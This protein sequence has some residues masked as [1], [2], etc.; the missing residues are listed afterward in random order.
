MNTT[1][2]LKNAIKVFL[3]GVKNGDIIIYPNSDTTPDYINMLETA[4][5]KVEQYEREQNEKIEFTRVNSDMYGNPRYVCHY[6]NLIKDSDKGDRAY[7]LYELALK[8][9]KK[10]G[11]RK[12]NNKQ[13][14]GGI[15]FQ[16]YNI[17]DTERQI[18]EFL[19]TL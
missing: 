15:V 9:A 10:L 19:K 17:Q 13:Y 11:G 4:V 5:N 1:T 12:F 3:I 16:S 8:R 14:G 7:N 2:E 18:K 6:L